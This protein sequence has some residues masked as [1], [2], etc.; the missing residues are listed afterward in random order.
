MRYVARSDI[1]DLATMAADDALVALLRTLDQFGGDGTFW[2]WAK[3][4]VQLER[5]GQHPPS[6]PGRTA[7]RW[8]ST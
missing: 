5:T 3:R 6:I 4:F 1:H 8:P 2:T 7:W